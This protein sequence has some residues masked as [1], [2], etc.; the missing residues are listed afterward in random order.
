MKT[1]TT[2][3]KQK[4]LTAVLLFFAVIVAAMCIVLPMVLKEELHTVL[5]KTEK[6]DFAEVVIYDTSEG[7]SLKGDI[8]KMLS[9]EIKNEFDVK[10]GQGDVLYTFRKDNVN[11]TYRPYI[12][13]EIQ[14]SDV[15]RVTVTNGYGKFSVYNDGKGN[16][17]F[18]GAEK[19]L[20]NSQI[21]AELL[22]QARYML[23]DGYVE[24]P[25]S[26]ADY[27][28]TEETCSAKVEVTD[29]NGNVNTVFVGNNLIG[30]GQYYMK[31]TEKEYVYIMDSGAEAFFNDIRTYLDAGVVK[32]IEE[33]QR[34][35]LEKFWL[36]KNG[37]RFF[38][39]E[40]IPDEERVGVYSNQLHRMTFPSDAQVLNTATLYDMFNECGALSGAGVVEYALSSKENKDEVFASYG[41]DAPFMQV[42][43]TLQGNDCSFSLGRTEEVD[44]VVYY[45]VYSDYQ[46]TIVMVPASSMNF[47]SYEIIDLFQENV[48]QYNIN[49]V[50]SVE[51]KYGGKSRTFKLSGVGNDLS[52]TE[53]MSGKSVD[54]PSFRQFYISLL[55]IT[56][57]GYS[58]FSGTPAD[59]LPHMLTFS[60]NLKEGGKAV[61]DFYSESTMNCHMVIDGKSGFK[62]ARK[63][64]DTVIENCEKLMAGETIASEF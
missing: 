28:L 18:E 45:Y 19:N 37:A 13:P 2:L 48:F 7:R 1:T 4:T 64:I 32:P 3:S 52:V 54:T 31:H 56:I 30:S 25:S 41:L 12:C 6:G 23:S 17:F 21:V 53:G 27:G 38:E 60:V 8:E 62:T 58:T 44:G 51:L 39:C 5:E 24:N 26:L 29:K 55:N 40:I 9:G 46:D 36:D 47:I 35:Y 20:Y 43:F 42:G 61:Y 22:L 33:Q 50:E 49:G 10:K 57:G 14:L 59:T 34:N 16:F 11:V 63:W 15:S